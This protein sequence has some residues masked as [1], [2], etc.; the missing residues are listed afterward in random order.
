MELKILK[1]KDNNL[2]FFLFKFL[3]IWLLWKVLIF[4]LG[5][6]N[7]PINE[8]LIPPL[9]AAWEQL[10]NLLR[11]ALIA[12]ASAVLRLMGFSVYDN[13]YTMGIPGYM[14]LS[15][16]NYCL[17]FQLMFYFTALV[18]MAEVNLKTKALAIVSGLFIIQLLNLIRVIGLNLLVVYKPGWTALSHDYLFNI[19]VLGVILTY[20]YYLVKRSR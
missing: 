20:Y 18:A 8:R 1:D 4:I 14:T 19:V 11:H 2:V 9:S 3:A 10:N 7:T 5:T 15:I 12:C 17:G 6:E 16:G 13:G